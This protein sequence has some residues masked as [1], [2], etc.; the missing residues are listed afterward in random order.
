MGSRSR[1]PLREGTMES[2]RE[3]PNIETVREVLQEEDERVREEP[4]P[5]QE[6]A[7]DGEN[8]DEAGSQ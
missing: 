7:G 4:S 1:F 8:E 2:R 6:D 5:P 3:R